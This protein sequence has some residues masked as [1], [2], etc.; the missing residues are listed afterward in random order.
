[1]QGARNKHL[2]CFDEEEGA[3]PAYD[4]ACIKLGLSDHLNFDDYELLSETASASHPL[5]KVRSADSR[6]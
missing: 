1:V 2:G 4:H 6:E 3:A 5:H